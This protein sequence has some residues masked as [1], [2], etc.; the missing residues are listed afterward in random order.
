MNNYTKHQ[1]RR[2]RDLNEEYVEVVFQ[3]DSLNFVPGCA[4]TLYKGPDHPVFIASGIQE[5]WCRLILR[6]DIFSPN[7]NQANLSIKLNL[8]IENKLQTLMAEQTPSFIFDTETIGAFFSYASTHPEV[9]CRVCYLGENKIQTEWID[10]NHDLLKPSDVL[11]MRGTKNLYIT[12]NR[13]LLNGKAE[14]LLNN[15]KGSFIHEPDQER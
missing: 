11:K 15:C 3:K 2:Y 1:I 13:D 9:K 14:K 10:S 12:G 6:K 8:E 5:C 7:L 4:V